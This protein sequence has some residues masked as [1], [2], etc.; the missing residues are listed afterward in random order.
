MWTSLNLSFVSCKTRRMGPKDFKGLF[1][2]ENHMMRLT[3]FIL[4]VS[5]VWLQ[6]VEVIET[7]LAQG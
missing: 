5:R 1:R 2:L 3:G 6:N 4:S 7:G